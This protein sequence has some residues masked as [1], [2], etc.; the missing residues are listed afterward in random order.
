MAIHVFGHCDV[1]PKSNTVISDYYCPF[2]TFVS[3]V[4]RKVILENITA[5]K[6]SE[7]LPSIMHC[8]CVLTT[9]NTIISAPLY[10]SMVSLKIL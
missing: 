1:K 9:L 5:P 7:Y 4:T 2:A 3:Q 10:A 6:Y 8:Q